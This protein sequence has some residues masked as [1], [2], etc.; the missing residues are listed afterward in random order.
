MAMTC[1]FDKESEQGRR[2]DKV[3]VRIPPA[4]NIGSDTPGIKPAKNGAYLWVLNPRRRSAKSW[5]DG[6]SIN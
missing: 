1:N 2:D 4:Q 3:I 5:R 6:S